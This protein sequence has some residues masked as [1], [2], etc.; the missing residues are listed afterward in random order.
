MFKRVNFEGPGDSP[1]E[2]WFECNDCTGTGVVEFR[3]SI[4]N[5]DDTEEGTCP[6]CDGDGFIEGEE[7]DLYA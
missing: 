3:V 7:A 2:Y 1:D 6:N 4:E 5:E